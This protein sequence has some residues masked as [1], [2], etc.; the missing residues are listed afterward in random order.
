LQIPAIS[1]KISPLLCPISLPNRVATLGSRESS[2]QMEIAQNQFVNLVSVYGYPHHGGE[3]LRYTHED[4]EEN[5]VFCNMIMIK[6]HIKKLIQNA[7]SKKEMIII[8]GDHQDTPDNSSNFHYGSCRIPKHPLVI[9]KICQSLNL[10]CS[11]YNHIETLEKPIISRHGRKGGRFINA[12]YT[13]SAGLDKITGIIIIS[14]AGINSDHVMVINKIDLGIQHF[15]MSTKKEERIDF[16]RI[17]NI[18]VK[19]KKGDLHPT[20]NDQVYKGTDFARHAAL[21]YNMKK[22][23]EDPANG[24]MERI[25]S[26]HQDLESLERDVINRT[27]THITIEDQK[28]RQ[29]Y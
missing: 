24:Y 7:H 2:H 5:D 25:K 23:V 19:L 12:M 15:K 3:K 4:F 29:A 21:Y 16:K 17:M 22:I 1:N 11:I 10:A 13:C 6:S 18:P 14:D 9:V 8:F 26:I 20:L 28:I 27:M